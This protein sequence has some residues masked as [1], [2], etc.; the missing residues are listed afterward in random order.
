MAIGIA[1][2]KIVISLSLSLRHCLLPLSG[3]Q[4]LLLDD[5]PDLM[6][7]VE[8]RIVPTYEVS[9]GSACSTSYGGLIF[10]LIASAT[11]TF[12]FRNSS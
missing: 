3:A 5:L 8:V 2:G 12:L 11:A 1:V 7:P 4:Y 9:Q 10:P 6:L